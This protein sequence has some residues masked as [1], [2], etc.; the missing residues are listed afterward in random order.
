MKKVE[1]VNNGETVD[2]YSNDELYGELFHDDGEEWYLL[3][4][5]NGERDLVD[6]SVTYYDSLKETENEIKAELENY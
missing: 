3:Q 5:I 2:V 4:Y 1:F 6:D